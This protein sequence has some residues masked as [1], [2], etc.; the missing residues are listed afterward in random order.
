MPGTTLVTGA[1]SGIGR[2]LARLAAKDRRDVVLVARRRDRLEE[3]AGEL[4]ARYGVVA[5]I[6][7]ADLA[8]PVS[9]A[10]VVHE[11]EERRG[12][13]EILVNAA[14]LGVHGLFSETPLEKELETIRVNVL[15]LTELT[16]LCVERMVRRR[17]GR[18]LNVASTAAFQPGPLMAVYYATKAYVLWFTEAIDEELRGT[19]V[20]ATALCP[21]PTLTEFQAKAGFGDVPLFR[22]PLVLEAATV[23]RAGWEGALRGKRV[24]VPGLANRILAAG[25]RISP[26]QL[27]TRIAR[28]L[29]ENRTA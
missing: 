26:R 12:P 28:K 23:A 6:V 13:I 9:A 3:L 20:T 11:A 18:I 29:Q 2:E 15:A 22:G 1:S 7:A 17:R 8:Q 27:A 14:G 25:A 10:Q 5:E 16:K 19:G 4:T 21:G 24:V